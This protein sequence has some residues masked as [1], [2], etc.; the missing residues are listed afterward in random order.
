MA[1]LQALLN[2]M[3]YMSEI[4]NSGKCGDKPE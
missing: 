2:N 4:L 1:V 3:R